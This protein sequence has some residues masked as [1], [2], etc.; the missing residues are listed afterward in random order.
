LPDK[1]RIQV[2]DLQIGMAVVELD[3]P[4][5]E[6][7]FLLQGFTIGNRADITALQNYS[8][9]VYIDPSSSTIPAKAN[10]SAE[11][12]KAAPKETFVKRLFSGKSNAVTAPVEQEVKRATVIRE[13]T[14]NLVKSCMDDLVVGNAIN[15]EKLKENITE[16]VDSIVRNPDAMMW[17]TRLQK[18]DSHTSQHSVNSCILAVTFGRYIGLPKEELENIAIGALMHDIGKLQIPTEIL[19]KPGKLTPEER[20]VVHKHPLMSRNLLMAAGR[21]LAPAVDI[22]YTHHERIDGSGYP[23]GLRGTSLTPFSRM[24]AIID[25]YDTMTSEQVYRAE[26]APFECL[27]HLNQNKGKLFDQQLVSLFIKM[28]GVFPVGSLVELTNG[29]IGIV[30]TSN[31]DDNLRPKVLVMLDSNKMPIERKIVNLAR[32][33]VDSLGRPIKIAKTLRKGD[34]GIDQ[35][36]LL[37]EGVEF[38]VLN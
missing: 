22:A 6:T 8:E 31:R 3:R 26:L 35:Q 20:R 28:I 10:T 23:R 13:N 37:E 25:V 18:K 9:Y 2:N 32:K 17:L 33:A 15:E 24:I 4:W 14:S 12:K 38:T 21:Y 34:Y 29:E 1:V 5:I 30:I 36:K 16:T 11:K 7:P 19:N 27:K